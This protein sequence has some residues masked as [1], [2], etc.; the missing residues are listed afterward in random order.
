M[1]PIFIVPSTYH[2][3]KNNTR[4]SNGAPIAQKKNQKVILRKIKFCFC[5]FPISGSFTKH[6]TPSAD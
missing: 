3:L 2:Y 4:I 1:R 6:N 5:Y